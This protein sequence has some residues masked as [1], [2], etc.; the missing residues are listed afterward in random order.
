LFTTALCDPQWRPSSDLLTQKW[1]V[2]NQESGR[3]FRIKFRSF[4]DEK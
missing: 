2:T 4:T 1:G 3:A